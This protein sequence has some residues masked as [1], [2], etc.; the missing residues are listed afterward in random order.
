M[1]FTSWPDFG[2]LTSANPIIDVIQLVEQYQKEG[3]VQIRN[4]AKLENGLN[5][6]GDY[7]TL[8]EES[9]N[10]KYDEGSGE[11]VNPFISNQVE[12]TGN[13][14][15]LNNA[16]NQSLYSEVD[17][18]LRPPPIVI[19]CSAGVGRTGTFCC[20]SN[21]IDRFNIDKNVDIFNTVKQI[22]DQR[23][24][25]VQTPDQ[26]QFCYTGLIEYVIRKSEENNE[27]G[28]QRLKKFLYEFIHG[29]FT[30]DSE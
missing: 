23:A 28:T 20:L 21:S 27:P 2:V 24:F 26:Y 17:D 15:A 9:D 6:S 30:S 22:R 14:T 13:E 4:E 12:S 11:Y 10:N 25:S 5:S 8:N 29:E 7:T 18:D 1:Q 3:M 19:H 16:H